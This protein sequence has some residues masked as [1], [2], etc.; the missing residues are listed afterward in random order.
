MMLFDAPDSLGGLGQRATTIVAPQA[1]A[2]LNSQQVQAH[3]RTLAHKLLEAGQSPA[4]T[5]N[6]AYLVTLARAADSTE[7]AET[8]RYIEQATGSYQAAGKPDAAE[9][10]WADVCQVLFGLNEFIYID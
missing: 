1:L 4:E 5:L 10:A 9:L 2:M 3:A 8:L 6:R 7:Q